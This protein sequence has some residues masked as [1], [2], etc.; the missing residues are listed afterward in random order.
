MGN[1]ILPLFMSNMA[2]YIEPTHFQFH[3]KH[4]KLVIF[5]T[6]MKCLEILE[7]VSLPQF[8]IKHLVL[9]SARTHKCFVSN[10]L[11]CKDELRKL[12]R[13]FSCILSLSLC[14]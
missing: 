11:T 3:H 7:N 2:A 12:F 5:K 10:F 14:F 9:G 8:Q 13:I 1:L 6:A 4:A